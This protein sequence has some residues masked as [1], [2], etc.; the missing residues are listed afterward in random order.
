[1]NGKG[2]PTRTDVHDFCDKEIAKA[3]PY[4]MF[5]VGANEGWMSVG[6]DQ[7]AAGFVLNAI[8]RWWT[9]I[10]KERYPDTTTPVGD[11]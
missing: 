8:R 9:T 5:D 4:G 3:I 10:D 11:G 6:D 2:N 1:M 7:E